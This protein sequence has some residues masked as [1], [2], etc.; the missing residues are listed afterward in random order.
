MIGAETYAPLPSGCVPALR[1][2]LH[3][4]RPWEAA[5][6][7][8][9]T[10]DRIKVFPWPRPGEPMKSARRKATSEVG[11]LRGWAANRG[12]ESPVGVRTGEA[13][14]LVILTADDVGAL[15]Q[16][17]ARHG[18]LPS[19]VRSRSRSGK[20]RVW[21]SLPHGVE[22]DTVNHFTPGVRLLSD[23]GVF[24]LG[25]WVQAPDAFALAPLPPGWITAA[26]ALAEPPI[27][28]VRRFV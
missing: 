18:P 5:A 19:T 13:S 25:P 20:L 27:P 11:A 24:R 10:S 4:P 9:S 15:A 22:I 2:D 21:C 3:S 26:K 17:E 14:R 1:A 6:G 28:N 8:V 23:G 12:L 7:L 16:A